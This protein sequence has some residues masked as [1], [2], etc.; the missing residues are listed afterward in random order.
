MDELICL[1][2]WA[3]LDADPLHLHC[4]GEHFVPKA[5]ADEAREWINGRRAFMAR[6]GQRELRPDSGAVV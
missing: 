4:T 5:E 6:T 3:S 1:E 2:C